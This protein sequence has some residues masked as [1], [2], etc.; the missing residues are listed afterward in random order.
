MP[1][2]REWFPD[3]AAIDVNEP[4]ITT[5]ADV[6]AYMARLAPEYGTHRDVPRLAAEDHTSIDPLAEL[7]MMRPD[8]HIVVVDADRRDRGEG[9]R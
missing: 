3:L 9:G 7:R 1:S 6:E 4:T 8:A 5:F 2:L